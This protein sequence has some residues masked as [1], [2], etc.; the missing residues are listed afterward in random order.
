MSQDKCPFCGAE[1][2]QTISTAEGDLQLTNCWNVFKDG[3]LQDKRNT[4]CYNNNQIAQQA[5]LLREC[6]EVVEWLAS[7]KMQDVDLAVTL[8]I[9]A[10]TKAQA[11]LPKLLKAT[12]GKPW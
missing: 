9:K 2:I 7:I 12:E 11:L 1:V 8:R 3:E 4:T 5:E 10:V 6:R